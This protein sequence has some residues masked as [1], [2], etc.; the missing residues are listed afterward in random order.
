MFPYAI[1]IIDYGCGLIMIK[2]GEREDC[3]T[4]V[5]PYKQ[6]KFNNDVCCEYV[7]NSLYNHFD[8]RVLQ[9]NDQS[10]AKQIELYFLHETLMESYLNWF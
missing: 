3:Y 9:I 5:I 4:F 7:S 6:K 1:A 8:M 2:V 10:S